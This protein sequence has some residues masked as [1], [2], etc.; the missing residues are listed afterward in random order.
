M[1]Y[2]LVD[3]TQLA[4]QWPYLQLLEG[5]QLL[6]K[7][8]NIRSIIWAA[9]SFVTLNDNVTIFLVRNKEIL[10]MTWVGIKITST[11]YSL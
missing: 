10:G 1:Q 3:L 4:H 11:F 6:K 7:Y 9:T 2:Y 8:S 5:V